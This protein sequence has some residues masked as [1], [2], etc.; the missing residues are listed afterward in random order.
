[1]LLLTWD[2]MGE[3][4]LFLMGGNKGSKC[5]FSWRQRL[6]WCCWDGARTRNK[7]CVCGWVGVWGELNAIKTARQCVCVEQILENN[8]CW[9][10][11][12]WNFFSQ[13]FFMGKSESDKKRDP[14]LTFRARLRKSKS[15]LFFSY[16]CCMHSSLVQSRVRPGLPGLPWVG[17]WRSPLPTPRA[18]TNKFK[19]NCCHK[20]WQL[21]KVGC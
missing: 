14:V 18:K 20:P 11:E 12:Y 1:M 7:K 13:P 9:K 15:E 5:F 8:C 21:S 3:E 4:G 19:F 10:K 16:G 17:R 6:M 2:W